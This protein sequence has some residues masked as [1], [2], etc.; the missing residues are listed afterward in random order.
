MLRFVLI[1][2]VALGLVACGGAPTA[3]VTSDSVISALK[4]AG[5]EAE[6]PTKMA[7][8]DFGVAPV[9]C[10]GT[11][12]LVPSLGPDNGGRVFICK[13]A[14]DA[15]KTK[16]AYD[17]MGKESGLLFSWAFTKGNVVVQINGDMDEAQAKQYET[18][19]NALP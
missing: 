13:N 19:I 6:A 9:L 16:A 15:A 5:L 12:F 8:N 18:I 14:D 3:Q 1:C 4:A 7:P 10:E 11:R 17:A 2:I